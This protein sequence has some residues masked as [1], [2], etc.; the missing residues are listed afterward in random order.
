MPPAAGTSLGRFGSEFPTVNYYTSDNTPEFVLFEADLPR[1]FV[2]V[3]YSLLLGKVVIKYVGKV[4]IKYLMS[5]IDFFHHLAYIRRRISVFTI[6]AKMLEVYY[7]V[8]L[9]VWMN[10]ESFAKCPFTKNNPVITRVLK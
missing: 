9:P 5:N 2:N 7:D 6:D 4:I 10:S 8:P 3:R 1:S